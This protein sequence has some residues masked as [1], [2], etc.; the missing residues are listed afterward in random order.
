MRFTLSPAIMPP[1]PVATASTIGGVGRDRKIV[2]TVDASSA[3]E[4]ARF[5]PRS[6]KCSTALSRV[7]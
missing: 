3:G 7:S 6:T 2:S 4:A 5:A 1:S